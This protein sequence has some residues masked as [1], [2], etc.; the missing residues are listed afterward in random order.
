[1]VAV[2]SYSFSLLPWPEEDFKKRKQL[3]LRSS[4]PLDL[5]AWLSHHFL[6]I[7]QVTGSSGFSIFFFLICRTCSAFVANGVPCHHFQDSFDKKYFL[8]K[9]F[10]SSFS[11]F[12]I[13]EEENWLSV[14]DCHLPTPPPILSPTVCPTFIPIT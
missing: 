14:V 11:E 6:K 9:R 2:V 8:E 1:M 3:F 10:N 13:S 4:K 12:Q 7:F 5:T